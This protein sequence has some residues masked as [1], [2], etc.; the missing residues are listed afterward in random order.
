MLTPK[1]FTGSIFVN[2]KNELFTAGLG[3]KGEQGSG[4]TSSSQELKTLHNWLPP[5]LHG[6]DIVDLAGGVNHSVL[7]LANGQVFG[8][9]NGRKGQLG[10]PAEVVW[11]PR[12]FQSLEFPVV[13]AVCGRE[14]TYLVGRNGRHAIL[15]SNKHDVKSYDT[16]GISEEFKGSAASWGS[17]FVLEISGRLHSWGR[18]DHGQLAPR[19]SCLPEIVDIAA[20]S[21]HVVALT[22]DTLTKNGGI[23]SW[24]WGEHG[25]CGADVN[26]NGD[27]KGRWNEIA[28]PDGSAKVLGVGAGCATSFFWTDT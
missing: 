7:V 2:D 12:Q 10:E 28:T 24:G 21:E 17:L 15:G 9:G 25:N 13:Q 14:F 1:P 18:N 4:Q 5:Q 22:K 11:S 19:S 16:A 8:W 20:G 3:P 26:E 23:I 6:Q 27:V